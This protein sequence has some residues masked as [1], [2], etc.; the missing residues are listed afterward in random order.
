M[1]GLPPTISSNHS[2]MYAYLLNI[3]KNFN[4]LDLP[5]LLLIPQSIY[6]VSTQRTKTYGILD[7][8]GASTQIGYLPDNSDQIGK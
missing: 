7:L 4:V 8:G 6:F 5:R 1:D 2:K 3:F